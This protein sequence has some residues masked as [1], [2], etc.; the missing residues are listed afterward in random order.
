MLANL[1]PKRATRKIM[2]LKDGFQKP[3]KQQV[4]VKNKVKCGKV[5][6]KQTVEAKSKEKSVE[7]E[8]VRRRSLR[9][10][11]KVLSSRILDTS[12]TLVVKRKIKSAINSVSQKNNI[13][14]AN[15]SKK[16][17]KRQEKQ[18]AAATTTN[19]ATINIPV[20]DP[21]PEKPKTSSSKTK[22]KQTLLKNGGVNIKNFF[23]VT[24]NPS[25]V[26]HNS[27]NN[28]VLKKSKL[29]SVG[30]FVRTLSLRKTKLKP[31]KQSE[32][33][34]KPKKNL[35][36]KLQSTVQTTVKKI[37]SVAQKKQCDNAKEF[38][39][40]QEV[41][42][43]KKEDHDKMPLLEKVPDTL[44][45]N[46]LPA[47]LPILTPVVVNLES[48]QLPLNPSKPTICGS[49]CRFKQSKAAKNDII[50][51]N[52][53]EIV[54][55]RII[56]DPPKIIPCTKQKNKLRK[57]NK[58][59]SDCIAM[60]TNKLQQ[61][62]VVNDPFS[63]PIFSFPNVFVPSI[64]E[65][66]DFDSNI[67][68]LD[69]SKKIPE[70]MLGKKSNNEITVEKSTVGEVQEVVEGVL[71]IQPVV[72]ERSA[73]EVEVIENAVKNHM[74]RRLQ[75]RRSSTRKIGQKRDSKLKLKLLQ[76]SFEVFSVAKDNSSSCSVPEIVNDTHCN[77]VASPVE[78]EC[79]SIEEKKQELLTNVENLDKEAT[80]DVNGI[81]SEIESN[82]ESEP[83]ESSTDLSEAIK[84][85]EIIEEE[86]IA[87]AIE[88]KSSEQTTKDE[89]V[90]SKLDESAEA[91][92]I[93]V[94]TIDDGEEEVPL[95]N[96]SILSNNPAVTGGS[97][98]EDEVPLSELRRSLY[99]TK[100]DEVDVVDEKTVDTIPECSELDENTSET[101]KDD[102]LD[103]LE[104]S[105]V[106]KENPVV[107][108]T[109]N[110]EQSTAV[111]TAE[112]DGVIV[113]ESSSE[114]EGTPVRM[115]RS[116]R[117]EAINTIEQK[118]TETSFNDSTVV[119]I[120][121]LSNKQDDYVIKSAEIDENP[122]ETQEVE[123]VSK[124]V[125]NRTKS[126][127]IETDQNSTE[128]PTRVL[129]SRASSIKDKEIDKIIQNKFDNVAVRRS[130]SRQQKY[131]AQ[132]DFN[133]EKE[134]DSTEKSSM[135]EN[136]KEDTLQDSTNL[137]VENKKNSKKKLTEKKNGVINHENPFE[138]LNTWSSDAQSSEWLFKS[139][140]K[141]QEENNMLV[142]TLIAKPDEPVKQQTKPKIKSNAKRKKKSTSN[143]S[144]IEN[145][146]FFCDICSKSFMR[147]DSLTKHYKTLIHIAKLSEIEAKQA[148]ESRLMEESP[149]HDEINLCN[150]LQ[151][152][153]K[154]VDNNKITS[155]VPLISS[156]FALNTSNSNTLKLA[157]IIN[158]VLNK[159]VEENSNKN[160]NFSNIILQST[161]TNKVT[162]RC[163]SLGERKSFESDNVKSSNVMDFSDNFGSST[164][165]NNIFVKTTSCADSLL[166]KQISLLENIIENRTSLNY[167]DDISVSSEN[168]ST[169]NSP[170]EISSIGDSKEY[171]NNAEKATKTDLAKDTNNFIKPVQYEEIS[172][173]S[174]NFAN[175]FEEQKSR[176]TLN[177]D[178]ELFLECCSL[179]KSSS[180]VSSYSKESSKIQS[181]HVKSAYEPDWPEHKT[182]SVQCQMNESSHFMSDASR[183]PTPLGDNFVDDGCSNT[184]SFDI[185][186]KTD[187]NA[188]EKG[189]IVMFEDIS[190][191][192]SLQGQSMLAEKNTFNFNF[193][194]TEP[195]DPSK[196]Q[197]ADVEDTADKDD[198]VKNNKVTSK[199]AGM[200]DSIKNKFHSLKRKGRRR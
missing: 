120:D 3:A 99:K 154:Y 162:K 10:I 196:G 7:K 51:E 17:H 64:V 5:I 121:E 174:G 180:E 74:A 147:N 83:Q 60:L 156:S 71:E 80:F 27:E 92:E 93:T 130:S 12:K 182:F 63:K 184:V 192:K 66:D 123:Q 49:N 175:N 105:E 159:P 88:V 173:D 56:N 116:R 87:V 188:T 96:K 112:V 41:V 23:P 169:R 44:E 114:S 194:F 150:M 142:P 133:I 90:A 126:L 75:P 179:L 68:V 161:E 100:E 190:E 108:L 52:D 148:A 8:N 158:D 82:K 1:P 15:K 166:E 110:E 141:A 54:P 177:R 25:K 135:S 164:L 136:Q 18:A 157:D 67:E 104:R 165:D 57:P 72:K 61:K 48:N 198:V 199:L 45:K 200:V 193:Q 30:N 107:V 140:L 168:N 143:D 171:S 6:C 4:K 163:K 91:K 86:P 125:R 101:C 78:L 111:T 59:L 149:K 36:R 2:C 172:E 170:S 29:D 127:N 151:E 113:I 139:A 189:D 84:S 58:G 76:Q 103:S 20:T 185:K 19:A 32:E 137:T 77:T 132:A 94:Q 178:E 102:S 65:K 55:C 186:K 187:E 115:L 70:E 195:D 95:E 37:K 191:D 160:N 97:D 106:S 38:F 62:V 85:N 167:I 33:K 138:Y 43:E 34:P 153:E 197:E 22:K 117:I 98:S 24:K 9:R 16:S 39:R 35:K 28:D 134:N 155:D 53:E 13:P 119:T 152:S 124:D 26:N 11:S 42:E 50:K 69:L 109:S 31:Q 118:Q 40:G 122:N 79:N 128:S 176:K 144:N 129:R 46:E 89:I 47:D 81:V 14:E 145:K 21:I 131:K 181:F 73:C 183:I 146:E